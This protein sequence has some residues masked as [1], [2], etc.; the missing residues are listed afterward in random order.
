LDP[1]DLKLLKAS[2]MPKALDQFIT[3]KLICFI[4][5]KKVEKILCAG[6]SIQ[7]DESENRQLA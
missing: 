4:L 3:L 7:Q 6:I 2:V 5:N 1:L